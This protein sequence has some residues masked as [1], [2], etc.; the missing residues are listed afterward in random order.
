[1][2]GPGPEKLQELQTLF[3]QNVSHELRT[4]LAIIQG[5]AELLHAGDLGALKPEQQE[6]AFIIVNRA[7]ELRTLIERIGILLAIEA[8]SSATV[9]L[10][11]EDIVIEIVEQ[12]RARAEKAGLE[13]NLTVAPELPP[14][15]GDPYHLRHAV[16]C[17]IDNAIKFTPSGRVDVE[18]HQRDNQVYLVVA[19]TGI[20]IDESEFE[21][22]FDRFY[23][24]DGS[25]T[26]RYGGMGLGL[27][28]VRAV[29]SEHKGQISVESQPGHGSRF[30][31]SLPALP[32]E[33]HIPHAEASMAPRR[34]LVV[35]DEEN[36]ALTLQEGLQK[37][38]DCEVQVATSGEQ[39]LALFKEQAFDLLITDY[40]MP[41][42]DGLTLAARVRQTYPRTE[43]ILITA[44]GDDILRQQ[45][46][47]LS[48]LHVMDKPVK[49]KEIRDMALG[50]LRPQES[51]E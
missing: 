46:A 39:A 24:V 8:H 26:R 49:L 43:I 30:T 44:Y 38:P 50:T 21:A 18:V 34:I 33:A 40:K 36:V 22:I 2:Q 48:I 35:D 47:H 10:R 17:L 3:I 13:I 15:A 12:S 31:L 42:T 6:A 23:Q 4:P 29:A 28:V 37:L 9:P 45:A 14:I 1:M 11:L 19:D 27:T 7:H 25:S 51:E 5:Y 20:G 16:E 41:G 32:A